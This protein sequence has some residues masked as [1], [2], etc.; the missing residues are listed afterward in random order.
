MRLEGHGYPWRVW[1]STSDPRPWLSSLGSMGT[2]TGSGN[3]MR[4][5]STAYRAVDDSCSGPCVGMI[6]TGL[7]SFWLSVRRPRHWTLR[8]IKESNVGHFIV[9]IRLGLLFSL[10]EFKERMDYLYKR[11]FSSDR[12]PGVDRIYLPG[13][14]EQLT[15]KRR[16]KKRFPLQPWKSIV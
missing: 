1:H 9:A 14:L 15:E 3:V 13:G 10:E 7:Q 4:G 8:P 5:G 2:E 6:H 16:G 11:V 12:R